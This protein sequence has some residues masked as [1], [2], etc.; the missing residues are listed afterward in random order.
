[1]EEDF[2]P[3]AIPKKIEIEKSFGENVKNFHLSWMK[4]S[5]EMKFENFPLVFLFS[6]LIFPPAFQWNAVEI[7]SGKISLK[8]FR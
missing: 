4:T 8:Y 2:P 6:F 1:M 5:E 3:P 7:F